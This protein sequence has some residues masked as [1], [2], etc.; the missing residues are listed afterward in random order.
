CI[1]INHRTEQHAYKGLLDA[2]GFEK[3]EVTEQIRDLKGKLIPYRN[4]KLSNEDLALLQEHTKSKIKTA[5]GE[6]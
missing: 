2:E 3:F 6:E 1:S 4:Q 5:V